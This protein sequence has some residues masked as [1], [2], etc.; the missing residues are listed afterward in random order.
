MNAPARPQTARGKPLTVYIK[1]SD[2]CNVGC[3]HCYLPIEVRA[4]KRRMDDA[5]FEAALGTILDMERRQNAPGTLVVWHGGEPLSLPVDYLEDRVQTAHAKIP[6]SVHAIQTSLIPYGPRWKDTIGRWFGGEIGS[7]IDFTQRTIKGS[8]QAY[9]DLWMEKVHRA[10]TDGYRV[11]PGVVP[12]INEVGKGGDIAAW[13]SDRGFD[14]WNIDRYNQFAGH[15]PLRPTNAA[16]AWFLTEVFD[17]VMEQARHGRFVA[18]NTVRAALGGVMFDTPGER[19]GGTCSHDFL[20]INPDGRTHA[21][22]DKISHEGFSRVQD[23]YG[24]FHA[25]AERKAWIRNHLLGHRNNHCTTCPFQTFCRSGCPLTPNTP[26][27][28]GECSGYRRHLHHVQTFCRRQPS[29]A[30]EYME[31]MA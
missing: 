8:P 31:S 3:S 12:S 15:D 9:Q 22:P 21:C 14:R 6:G 24:A 7:S 29:L 10:R 1:P 11:V 18:V 30:A 20:V 2:Y 5:T 25:S 27:T 23:G 13:M 28:E 4:D 17:A 19:W 16:H 26:D